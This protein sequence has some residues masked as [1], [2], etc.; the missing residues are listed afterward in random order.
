MRAV[1]AVAEIICGA[2]RPIRPLIASDA[3]L[4]ERE[5]RITAERI[6][7]PIITLALA[8]IM[9]PMALIHRPPRGLSWP[10]CFN[11]GTAYARLGDCHD[12]KVS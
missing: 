9:G 4:D 11:P 10:C 8:Q 6:K 1:L 5:Y 7:R 2:C 3:G 12:T